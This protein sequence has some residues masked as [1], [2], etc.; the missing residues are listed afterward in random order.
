MILT[1]L[2]IAFAV[3][4]F[5][6]FIY[7]LFIF[8]KFSFGKKTEGTPKRLPISIIVCAKNEEENIKKYFQTLVTQNYPDYEIVLIDDASSDETLELFES[9]EKQYPKCKIGKSSK[10]RSVL[11]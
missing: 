2:L 5:I 8:G 11:G 3:I 6:Q 9:Y 10:Q 1:I 7:Y 4:V